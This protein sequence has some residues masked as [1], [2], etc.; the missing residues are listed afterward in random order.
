MEV[1]AANL[2]IL[3]RGF[4]GAFQRGVKQI[5]ADY[6]D[7]AQVTPSGTLE[8]EYGWLGEM[9][10]VREWLGPRVLNALKRYG[11]KIR[12]RDWETT[13]EVDRNVIEDDQ[14]GV[15]GPRF[16][17]MGQSIARGPNTLVYQGLKA[18]FASPCYDGQFFFDTDHPVLDANGNQIT[19]ANTDPTPGGGPSWFL[20][21]TSMKPMIFQDRKPFSLVAKDRPDDDNVFFTK[22]FIYGADARYNTGYGFW[23]YCW[24]STQPLTADN[25][26]TARASLTGMKW[27]YEAPIG[28][29]PGLL[30]VPPA[31]ELAARQ[32]VVAD[33]DQF[34]ATNIWAGTAT[35]KVSPWL[36]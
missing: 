20:I 14:F 23:Q 34:G 28:V 4:N 27:D 32:V 8:E 7:I 15:Y 3:F 13:V 29:M 24:G 2:Q 6:K 33:R 36:A 22:K 9:P 5:P 19:V 21:D 35:L 18:G 11:Y 1:T 16:E 30:V 31:L 25:Y 10:N 26:A 17:I 12:N